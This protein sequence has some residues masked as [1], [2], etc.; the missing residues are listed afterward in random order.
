MNGDWPLSR[1]LSHFREEGKAAVEVVVGQKKIGPPAFQ[2]RENQRGSQQVVPQQ[3]EPA[4]LLIDS[5]SRFWRNH[6]AVLTTPELCAQISKT[7]LCASGARPRPYPPPRRARTWK[8]CAAKA[9]SSPA[10][11]AFS[12]SGCSAALC[13]A[14]AELGLGLRLTVL[15]R[16]PAAFLRRHSRGRP[17]CLRFTFCKGTSPTFPAD[18]SSLR[19]HHPRRRRHD[20]LHQRR[21]GAGTLARHRR[22]HAPH[23]RSGA[24][25]RRDD[26]STSVPARF[27]ACCGGQPSG[28]KEDDYVAGPRR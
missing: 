26:C 6:L 12:A 22:R 25:Q 7:S 1:L 18:R 21:R 24:K 10:A 3:S 13:H 16:D 19:L 17:T 20:G 14:D 15:S 9:S 5:L 8:S 2:H 4:G 27:T 28:A 11:P 23:A